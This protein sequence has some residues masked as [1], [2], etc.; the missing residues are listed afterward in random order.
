MAFYT[1]GWE[2]FS[3]PSL[4]AL[5]SSIF[6]YCPLVLTPLNPPLVPPTLRF[7]AHW[8]SMPEFQEC[9]KKAWDKHIPDQHNPL[10]RLHIKLTRTG[11]STK[12]LGKILNLPT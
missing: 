8:T 5:S 9:I 7:E 10:A 3:N 1:P 6:N 12:N 11:K 4:H 2:Q